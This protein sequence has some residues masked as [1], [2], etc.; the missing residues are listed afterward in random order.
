MLCANIVRDTYNLCYFCIVVTRAL[1]VMII[2]LIGDEPRVVDAL[3]LSVDC[4][5][6]SLVHLKWQYKLNE[7]LQ[8][9]WV[10]YVCFDS[11]SDNYTVS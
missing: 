1:N 10:E 2:V 3:E 5:N 8:L 7:K 11:M 6:S 9:V 4:P